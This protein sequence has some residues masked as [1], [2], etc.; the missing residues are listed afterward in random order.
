MACVGCALTKVSCCACCLNRGV[1][2]EDIAEGHAPLEDSSEEAELVRCMML[3]LEAE[4]GR[5]YSTNFTISK[6]SP[7]KKLPG[8]CAI[9]KCSRFEKYLA[10]HRLCLQGLSL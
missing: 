9:F 6:S 4:S 3:H 2:C 5:N 10:S 8:S 7:I 1:S